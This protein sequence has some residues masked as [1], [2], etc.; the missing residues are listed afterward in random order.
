MLAQVKSDQL[1]QEYARIMAFA[2]GQPNDETYAAMLASL[3]ADIASIPDYFGLG[4]QEFTR[5][6]ASHFPGLDVASITAN[7][8]NPDTERN[9]ELDDVYKLLIA[10]RTGITESEIWM[11][12]MVAS[13]CQGQDHLWQDMG[14]WSR[15]QLSE[16]LMR[17]FPRLAA[18]NIN[19]MKWKKF[20]YKQLC[21]TEGIYT[22]RSPSCEVCIDYAKCFG[23]EI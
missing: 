21:A 1:D 5:L 20:F 16:L 23:P 17:N 6:L 15:S 10:N 8:R 14:L 9:E 18:K 4:V 11:A 12:R 13:A 22:C 19:N 3:Q 2:Y 7:G